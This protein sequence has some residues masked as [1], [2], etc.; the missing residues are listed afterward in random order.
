[1]TPEGRCGNGGIPMKEDFSNSA[2]RGFGLGVSSVAGYESIHER[3]SKKS[4]SPPATDPRYT[5]GGLSGSA[6]ARC[7]I[8]NVRLIIMRK[9]RWRSLSIL[10]CLTGGVVGVGSF[11][12]GPIEG[13]W[14][15]RFLDCMCTSRNLVEFKDG[16]AVLSSSHM[17]RYSRGPRGRYSKENGVWV[18]RVPGAKPEAGMELYPTWFFIRIVDRTNGEQYRGHRILWPPSIREARANEKVIPL[19]ESQK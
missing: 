1:M 2:R 12:P 7:S 6:A 9:H 18:W 11:A 16:I 3:T 13:V 4:D 8:N 14:Y 17:E 5:N 10:L 19:K 15:P